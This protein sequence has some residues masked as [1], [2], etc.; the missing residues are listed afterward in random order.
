MT[1][2][3]VTKIPRETNH[4][5]HLILTAISC[6]LWSPVWLCVWIVNSLNPRT[7][8]TQTYGPTVPN[9]S[10]SIYNLS[11]IPAW[12]DPTHPLHSGNR[13]TPVTSS[14]QPQYQ[15]PKGT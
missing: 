7:V 9:Y 1:T 6:G 8:T 13:S 10:G 14:E 5:L 2:H 3:Q 12:S 15:P 4:L 11:P